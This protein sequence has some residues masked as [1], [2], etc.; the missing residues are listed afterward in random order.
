[1][2]AVPW[3]CSICCPQLHLQQFTWRVDIQHDLRWI[4]SD[5]EPNQKRIKSKGT[6]FETGENPESPPA[7]PRTRHTSTFRPPIRL[8]SELKTSRGS[9]ASNQNNIKGCTLTATMSQP[10]CGPTT[11]IWILGALRGRCLNRPRTLALFLI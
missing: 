7:S 10:V 2:F 3:K 1:M 4:A 9:A 6:T 5:L 8:I 11:I